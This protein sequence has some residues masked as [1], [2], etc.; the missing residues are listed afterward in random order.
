M[1]DICKMSQ[2]AEKSDEGMEVSHLPVKVIYADPEFNCRGEIAAF[3]VIDLVKSIAKDG[4]QVPIKVRPRRPSDPQGYDFIIISGHRRHRAYQV[5]KKETIP[6][7]IQEGLDDFKARTLNA[8]ENLKR[9]DLNLLQEAKTIQHFVEAG[10]SRQQIAEE[11]G[12]STAWVQIRAQLIKMPKEIQLA[13]AAG[14]INQNQVRDLYAYRNSP[15]KQLDIVRKLKEQKERFEGK[16]TEIVVKRQKASNK[17]IRKRSEI[18]EVI[19][20]IMETYGPCF[21]TRALAWAAGEISDIEFHESFRVMCEAEG[22]HY[23]MPEWEEV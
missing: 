1:L 20:L 9:K 16:K 12:M 8:I 21:G 10:W 13:A 2:E 19:E 6:C 11:V 23:T 22:I 7:I 18:F 15:S 4:L 14:E 17:K 5:L 3:D